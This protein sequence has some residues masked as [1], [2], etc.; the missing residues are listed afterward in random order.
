M[1]SRSIAFLFF[2]WALVA[3][4]GSA[5][6]GLRPNGSNASDAPSDA[7]DD[8]LSGDA[9]SDAV[10]DTVSDGAMDTT[11]DARS[12]GTMDVVS[13]MGAGADTPSE[14]DALDATP[15]LDALDAGD[16][17]LD[18][19]SDAGDARDASDGEVFVPMDVPLTGPVLSRPGRS[20]AIVLS[21]DD[22]VA[23]AVN[24]GANSVSVFG[25]TPSVAP[26]VLR[27]AE[28][29]TGVNSEPW[30]VAMAPDGDSAYVVLRR[31]QQVV[32]IHNL[33]SGSP[34]L[35][36]TRATTGSEPTAM[37][38][39]PT[40]RTLYVSNWG[41]GTLSVVNTATMT[42]TATLDLNTPLASQGFVGP[43]V[44]GRRGLAHPRALVMTNNGDA[45]DD[46][47]V[48][49]VTEFFAKR[50]LTGVPT[51]LERF[52][53]DHVGV[54]YRIPVAT[55][56]VTVHT[57][58]PS[59]NM[60]FQAAD[61]T[62]AGCYPNQLYA[63]AIAQGRVFVTGTCVSPRGPVG[64]VVTSAPDG[65]VDGGTDAALDA[66]SDRADAGDV[67]DVGDAL[68][69]VPPLDPAGAN[70]RTQSTGAV[71]VL[72]VATGNE[73]TG[74]RVLLNQR[75]YA[76]YDA[77][78]D[79]DDATRRMPLLPVDIDFA[80][81]PGGGTTTATT[82][83]LAAYGADGVFRV[84][85][86]T[87]GTFVGVGSMTG[88]AFVD[89]G[90]VRAPAVA[91]SGPYGLAT[92]STVNGALTI[93]EFTRTVSAMELVGQSVTGSA[94]A[95]T[96]PAATMPLLRGR[97]FFV[98]GLGRWSF[99]GQGWNSCE[100]CHPDGLTDGIT[101]F[102][103]RGP[104][105]TP[106]L[107]ATFEAGTP[108]IMNWTAVFDEFSD[109]ELNTRGNSGG[110]GAVVHRRND[111]AN[112]PAITNADRIVFDGTPPVAPQR[113]TAEPNDG[114]NGTLDSVASPTGSNPVRTVLEDWNEMRAW[115]AT[116]RSPRA[117]TGLN[118]ADVA[119]GRMLFQTHNCAGCHGGA[120]WSNTAR[121]YTP[122]Q[123]A[124]HR[125]TGTLITTTWTRPSNFPASV[126]PA[127]A[128]FRPSPFDAAN[129]QITCV[130]R[131]VGTWA[132][133]GV[134]PAGVGILEVRANMVTVSQGANGFAPP[135][136]LGVAH[137]APYFHAGNAR[138]LEEVFSDT[139]AAHHRAYSPNFLTN[140]ATRETELRQ[141]V[142]FLL[143]IDSD[144][145]TITA[146]V[147]VTL[148]G[149]STTFEANPCAQYR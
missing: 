61:G 26:A 114:L 41:D 82:A 22:R 71:Y 92:L 36:P 48:L 89:L 94:E 100:A 93:N 99:K 106:S 136:L 77:R 67:G 16:V 5:L 50:R 107:D 75:Y 45:F 64:P 55:R 102:F 119:A 44:A 30:H 56:V 73:L 146:P 57:L 111:G 85:F 39:S 125:T 104:R 53:Q 62:V 11:S 141:L 149:T 105:Q 3:C 131:N 37:A 124:N 18:G 140:P 35:G 145:P 25:V 1:W 84:T 59:A 96:I 135:S 27:L 87:A 10:P 122:S 79:P 86:S 13:D 117:P 32:R 80:P 137:G 46:D 109:F 126:L 9:P 128:T 17:Q 142:A 33:R 47:E 129:D 7:P 110:V 20:A 72:D 118:T 78:R 4:D 123:T 42:T 138:S 143:S 130:L 112:P 43:G 63:A 28:V 21:S 54:V 70:F 147:R 12:D 8:F 69:P 15:A 133:N 98:T 121:F 58:L 60:G 90:A 40:G 81:G 132:M 95:S 38:L 144:T 19:S 65:G 76:L 14:P 108:R 2:S 52:D 120:R 34:V 103:A 113:A 148:P 29:A 127:M 49:F 91:G 66:P 139:F 134:A 74:S 51:G 83:Y 31:A 101:W 97:R 88:N 23:V 115:V 6:V 68:P 24:R 116:L